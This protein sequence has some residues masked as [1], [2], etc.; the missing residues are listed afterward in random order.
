[1]LLIKRNQQ[2]NL[3]VTV[4]S[5]KTISSPNYLFSFEHIMSKE[6]VQ[7]F[8]KNIST[9]TN[10]YDEF[11]FVEGKEPNNYNGAQ[12]PYEI[13]PFEGQYYYSV[14]ECFN[15][16]STNPQFA[17]EKLE[18]GRAIVEDSSIPD[19]Y[20]Y[21]YESEN[22]NNANY[23]YYTPGTNE[24]DRPQVAFQFNQQANTNYYS[25]EETFP[26]IKFLDLETGVV[27]TVETRLE[28]DEGAANPCDTCN[29][30]VSDIHYQ[31]I[32]TGSTWP[33][34]KV[35]MDPTEVEQKGY[36]FGNIDGSPSV[37][38][39][40]FFNF[41]Q[42]SIPPLYFVQRISHYNDG[43]TQQS[44]TGWSSTGLPNSNFYFALLGNAP[45]PF[46]LQISQLTGTS[47]NDVCNEYYG[48]TGISRKMFY[49]YSS[50]AE[51][52][53]T[54]SNSATTSNYSL[55]EC[56]QTRGNEDFFVG[57]NTPSGFRVASA[58]HLTG[59]LIYVDTC[60][61]PTP[62]P[63]PT[64]TT[65]PTPT[66]TSTTTPTPTPTTTNTPTPTTTPTTT[67]TNT[68]TTTPTN[69]PTTTPTNTP[70]NTPTT[71]PTP[72]PTTTQTPTPTPS[73]TPPEQFFILAENSDVLTAENNDGLQ[74][75]SAP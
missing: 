68:P 27:Q 17:Y 51:Y 62:T 56:T 10:R 59:T 70:T 21:T 63:T 71:T 4:S 34:F 40:T 57:Q 22:E 48:G 23:I 64:S 39:Y 19:L 1:M 72:T 8:P 12:G 46:S 3:A 65:T 7:F 6:T 37:T 30:A 41:V 26:D 36:E 43:T 5:S 9:S 69:T 18:E 66:P 54:E 16:G 13:F 45:A 2:N 31:E 47:V 74:Q 75:E 44:Q 49:S 60:V 55:T 61:L 20:S 11:T 14:Y 24:P 25:W 67:P 50:P 32:T 29:R 58:N 35:Y 42:S 33:G 53:W 28:S 73:A 52:W 38:G 15:T